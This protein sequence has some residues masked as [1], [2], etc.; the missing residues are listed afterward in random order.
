MADVS[1]VNVNSTDYNIKD[2]NAMH[3]GVDYVTAGKK[4]NTTLG[5]KATA[6]GQNTTA[7]GATSH[8]EGSN[9]TASASNAHAE[10]SYTT[11][12]KLHAHAEGSQ[13]TASGAQ[14]HSEGL[15]TTASGD[16][17]HS[18]GLSTTASG[19]ASHAEG[20]LCE[21][22]GSHAHAEGTWTKAS[23]HDQHAEGKYN[24]EDTNG[25][26]AH[27]IGGGTSNNARKNIFTVDWNGV[28]RDGT[29][30]RLLPFKAV[31]EAEYAALSQAEKTNGTAYFRYEATGIMREIQDNGSATSLTSGAL[32]TGQTITSYLNSNIFKRVNVSRN[33]VNAYSANEAKYEEFTLTAEQWP[34][35]Y[36]FIAL[37][38]YGAGNGILVYCK[39]EYDKSTRKVRQL[40]KNVSTNSI[41]ANTTGVACIVI[42][43]KSTM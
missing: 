1:K 16:Y 24:V 28:A 21:A 12:S 40:L 41:Q 25:T 29:E 37:A 14:A 7:S 10:G 4:A 42:L 8:A 43:A 11:A 20:S 26:Y 36:E 17:S 32:P 19:N 22:A 15:S 35:N 9:T 39:T 6:E 18:E 31:S 5:S 13:T 2:S 23:S 27:I 3:K 34:T 38:S 33:N 30:N